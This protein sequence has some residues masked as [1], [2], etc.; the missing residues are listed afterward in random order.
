MSIRLQLSLLISLL[1]LVIITVLSV[2]A[3]I[4]FKESLL[5]NI[6]A[7]LKA[8]GEGIRAQ[9]DER[10]DAD[11][12][13]EWRAIV[14]Y[15]KSGYAAD[16]RVWTDSESEDL[17]TTGSAEKPLPPGFLHPPAEKQPEVGGFTLFNIPERTA[18]GRTYKFRAL[19]MRQVSGP[20]T[21]NILVAR[22]SNHV[23]HESIEFLQLL[24]WFGGGI[25]LAA[26]L[27]VPRIVSWGLRPIS[28]AG[29]HLDQITHR[30]LQEE[31]QT[32]GAVPVELQ[33]FKSALDGMLV[34][35]NK[36]VQQQKQLTAD[37]THELRTPLA[38]MKS[39]LQTLRMKPRTVAECEEG[40]DDSLRDIERMEQLVSQ[41]LT[42]ARLDAV[43]EV[44]SPMEVR[45][46]LLLESLTEVFES[47]AESQGVRIVFD[48]VSAASVRG[49][50]NELR[51]LFTNLL[52]NALRYGP[53]RGVIRVNVEDGPG[54]RVAVCIHDEGGAIPPKS[55][56]HLFD[57]FYR[58][59]PSRSQ[60]FG[61]AGLGLAIVRR[62]VHRHHGG[63][64]IT[65]TPQTGTSVTVQLPRVE[66][67]NGGAN[68]ESSF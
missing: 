28:Y 9:L 10:G 38:I 13:A 30:N 20:Q 49:D 60:A 8:M 11:Y 41:L 19:W 36:A 25:M 1:T 33:P 43:D 62:I 53:P 39:T 68:P 48:G 52:D 5:G 66:E 42:L 50:E 2:A 51:Q 34:R 14:G 22:S 64:T 37:V 6:D 17:F 23:Y 56:P 27:L 57:R 61:G 3:S 45:L 16:C 12:E 63:I 58:V 18:M 67:P 65:S 59:D 55:L 26:L 15:G 21:T 40:M 24:L 46:D 54:S 32:M 47:R 35:L 31:T 4:E 29:R 7:T 44:A